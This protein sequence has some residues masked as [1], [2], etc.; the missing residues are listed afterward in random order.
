[1]DRTRLFYDKEYRSSILEQQLYKCGKCGV[2]NTDKL[3]HLHHIDY[4]KKNDSRDNLIFLCHPCHS[5]TTNAKF[6]NRDF[7]INYYKNKNR[8]YYDNEA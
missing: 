4:D 8:E 2:K 3:F 5:K 6:E 7:W 1:M